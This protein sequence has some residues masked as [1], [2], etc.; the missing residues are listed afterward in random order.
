M[1]R[2][3][4]LAIAFV[5]AVV[6]LG[7][8]GSASG[9]G[10]SIS[11]ACLAPGGRAIGCGGWHNTPVTVVWTTSDPGHLYHTSGCDTQTF[12]RDVASAPVTCQVFEDDGV[13]SA[14][15]TVTL[16]IDMT[17]PKVTGAAPQRP[18]DHDGWWNHP[19]PIAF[20]G[21]DATSGIASCDTVTY[22]QPNSPA[23]LATG[24]CRDYAGNTAVGSFTL[25]YDATPPQLDGVSGIAGDGRVTLSWH[26][27]SDTTFVDVV[28]SPG[29]KR[30]PSTTLYSGR[31]KRF[32]DSKASNRRT[33]RY[34]VIAYDAAGNSHA[35]TVRATPSTLLP[36]AGARLRGAPTLRWK[37]V[38]QADYYNVQIF[39]GRRKILSS[40]PART[41]LHL[42]GSWTFHGH[43]YTLSKG[44]YRWYVW[45]GFGARAAHRYG[46]L[47]GKS[48]FIVS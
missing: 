36:R 22:S 25:A 42:R 48:T 41:L 29:T 14:S 38:A 32:T 30:A 4:G 18:A 7:T 9:D 15:Q 13:G 16:H 5:T 46:G 27:S 39:R 34:T 45:P 3:A 6:A 10:P 35:V 23:A 28:R 40:W 44:R 26:A 43:R 37:P 2:R 17:P 24:G 12:T 19:I 21:T 8:A 31:A 33:Y 20:Q 1:R 47:I 11:Y